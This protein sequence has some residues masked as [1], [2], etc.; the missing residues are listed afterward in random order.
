M[1]N[2]NYTLVGCKSTGSGIYDCIDTVKNEEGRLK[3][4]KRIDLINLI[5]KDGV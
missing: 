5:K 3:D 4:F 2:K 1:N